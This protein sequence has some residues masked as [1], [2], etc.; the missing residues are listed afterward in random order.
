[1]TDNNRFEEQ[2]KRAREAGSATLASER[3]AVDVRY[4][5]SSDELRLELSDGAELL[6]PVSQLQGLSEA[7]PEAIREVE[8][9]ADG[10]ALHWDELD[11]HY[12]VPG[13]LRGLYGTR[14]WMRAIG[15]KG[16]RAVS[17]EKQRSSRENGARGGRP[18]AQSAEAS[19]RPGTFILK[20]DSDGRFLAQL[21]TSNGRVLIETPH[22]ARRSDVRE[23]V[24]EL[25][26]LAQ[27]EALLIARVERSGGHVL[28]LLSPG[29]GSDLLA[30]TR[31][32]R[33]KTSASRAKGVLCS[34]IASASQEEDLLVRALPG[35]S[36]KQVVSTD[37]LARQVA[38]ELDRDPAEVKRILDAI[39]GTI[40]VHLEADHKVRFFGLGTFEIRKRMARGGVKPGTR[41]RLRIPDSDFL[42]FVPSG[43]PQKRENAQRKKRK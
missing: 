26:K 10:L 32:Y 6:V 41:D 39:A 29:A 31:P 15:S 2:L 38:G 21:M 34:A 11:V 35:S 4:V 22:R 8:L 12:T 16:G 42:A 24:A 36:R 28:E 30:T 3:K 18:R 9:T 40:T 5:E 17:A 13:L 27:R 1:M 14:A 43:E 23:Y 20:Q 25:K 7:S 33:A 19:G 37:E